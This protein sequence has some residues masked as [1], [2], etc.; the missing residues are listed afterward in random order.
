V[1][2][3]KKAGTAT[4]AFAHLPRVAY[5]KFKAWASRLGLRHEADNLMLEKAQRRMPGKDLARDER[6]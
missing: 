1:P 2:Q 6:I 4:E 5:P 3:S